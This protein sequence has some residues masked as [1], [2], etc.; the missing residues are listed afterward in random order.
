MNLTLFTLLLKGLQCLPKAYDRVISQHDK[1]F[2]SRFIFHMHLQ[3]FSAFGL[4]IMN[5]EYSGSHLAS[6]TSLPLYTLH[7]HFGRP[8]TTSLPP[9]A[10]LIL[11]CLGF[12]ASNISP[13]KSSIR[14]KFKWPS[15]KLPI[16][17][18]LIHL[19][20]VL[21]YFGLRIPLQS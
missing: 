3:S 8:F 19:V 15:Y 4:A 5:F 1:H 7:A 20:V 11:I 13:G 10:K 9:L 18:V 17:P 12:H 14:T 6:P 2:S 16:L 21:K